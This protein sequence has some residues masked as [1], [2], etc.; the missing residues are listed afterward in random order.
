MASSILILSSDTGGGHRSAANALQDSFLNLYPDDVMVNITQVLEEAGAAPRRLGNIYNYLLRHHQHLMKY[1][2]WFVNNL[3]PNEFKWILKGALNYG[4]RLINKVTPDAIVSVHPMTQHMYAYFLKRLGLA[5][6]VPL[7]TVVTDP[8]SGF[9]KGWACQDVRQY[10]V[11]TKQ[12]KQQL[13]EYGIEDERIAIAGMPVHSRFQ[14][15]TDEERLNIKGELGLNP[16][17]FTVLMNAGWVGGG[18]IPA[19]LKSLTKTDLPI[20][21]LYVCGRSKQL[22]IQ[23]HQLAAQAPF[24]VHVYGFRS[25]LDRLMNASDVM[26]SKLGGL[27]TF[28]ALATRLPVIAD[29]TTPPMPQEA[30]TVQFIKES[31]AGHLLTDADEL[32]TYLNYLLHHP[33][34]CQEMREAACSHGYPGASDDIAGNIL[35]LIKS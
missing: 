34:V 1:Y 14:P 2:Y 13:I 22:L 7:I 35:S 31:G 15:V 4:R 6:R 26:V 23:G 8:Y 19:I 25:D 11:A 27:T 20:Q 28:E 21:V 29:V 5:E 9:W 12:A 24:P 3:R 10:Y 18:N 32:S 16:D 17:K 30:S 33:E